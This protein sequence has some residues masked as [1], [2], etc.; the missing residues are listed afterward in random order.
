MSI[1]S[2]IRDN[3]GLVAIIIFIAL[4]AF[5]L[6]DLISGINT[7][8]GGPSPAGT[9]AGE[10]I[11][12][13]E[14]QNRVSQQNSAGDELARGNVA[15]QV[16]Q[17]MVDEKV[18]KAEYDRIGLVV[19]GDEIYDM[20]TRPVPHPYVSQYFLQNQQVSPDQIK[21]ALA[22]YMAD[23]ASREQFKGFED[24]L[25]QSRAQERLFNMI[26]SAWVSSPA[27]AK[28]IYADQ[29]RKA[30]ISFLGVNY[31]AIADS[32]IPVSESDLRAYMKAHASEYEQEAQTFIRYIT[33]DINP[34]AADTV[35]AMQKL[36]KQMQPFAEAVRDSV[37][38][39]TKS[40][41]PYVPGSFVNIT[42][43]PAGLRDSMLTGSL[44]KVFGPV[45]EGG[46][47]KLYKLIATGE[48]EESNVK[49]NH[50]LIT[51]SGNTAADTAEARSK[52]AALANQANSGN[53]ATLAAEN[54]EDFASKGKG[55]SL[56]WVPR[57]Q[58]GED[59]DK[60]MDNA[61]VGSIVGPVK[62][63]GGFHVVQVVGKTSKT[64]DLAQIEEP[65]IAS[66]DTRRKIDGEANQLAAK[67]NASGDINAEAEAVGKV[68]FASAGLTKASRTLPGV[69]GGRDVIVWAL[70]ADQGETSKVFRVNSNKLVVAQVS[71]KTSEGLASLDDATLKEEIERKVR[72][73]RKGEMIKD[74]LAAVASADLNAM[75]DAYNAANGNGAYI[76]TATG[77][78]FESSSIPGIG[79]DPFIIGKIAGMQ[80][81]Q[82]S[83]P[84]VG[85]NGVYV[86]QVTG[87]T[88]APEPD[89]ATL[90]S[91]ISSQQVQ[92]GSSLRSKAYPALREIANVEDL[93]VEA[94]K[95]FE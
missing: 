28:K 29:N 10:S 69:N 26:Q 33:Y 56:G 53:F 38:T 75:R 90:A 81:G 66:T 67:L 80:E 31:T 22:S 15:D 32:T 77:I 23:E 94:E 51:V 17:Q 76:N 92:G 62:G 61:S 44:R 82:V 89:A 34:S 2:K 60:A 27:Q 79:A 42:G 87:V 72:E 37:Y 52:A 35:T 9:V 85:V 13:Q 7:A 93:R 36:T 12:Y 95:Q 64:F 16:W 45:R 54:S 59:F 40:S 5:I 20:F 24:F 3:I 49:I 57:G 83:K 88:A 46:I 70:F 78:T 25:A 65:I 4:I 11:S 73:E 1:L 18:L 19:T 14:F 86:I 48:A 47:F 41:K 63:R 39:M 84:I 74:K 71:N 91:T 30:N 21:Q 58:F 55:G 43:V 50:I 8:F 6:T 68:A